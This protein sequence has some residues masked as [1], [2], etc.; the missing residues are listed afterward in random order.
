MALT[1]RR[2]THA[3]ASAGFSATLAGLTMLMLVAP[4][5][6]ARADECTAIAERIASLREA[7]DLTA[8]DAAFAA[9]SR[10]DSPCSDK[11]RYCIGRSAALGYVA[12]L[13][14]LSRKEQNRGGAAPP[15]EMEAL[16]ARGRNLGAPW[17]LLVALGDLQL[18]QAKAAHDG[19][20]YGEAAL[21]YQLALLELTDEPAC[22]EYGEPPAASARQIGEIYEHM[23]TALLLAAPIKLATSKCS[24]CQWAFLS[25]I[26]DFTPAVR[27]LPITFAANS[28]EPTAEGR[29]AIAAL[30]Q[31]INARKLPRIVLS[32]H[33]DQT[34]SAD[35]NLKLSDRRLATVER[36]LKEGGFA[37]TVVKEPKGKSEP[38]Q[39]GDLASYAPEEIQRLN[40][41]I[42]LRAF[43]AGEA[44]S[45][46]R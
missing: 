17:Q 2:S 24:V 27:P 32:G 18:D 8:L 35:F 22:L 25:P 41:R 12:E 46:S 4:S 1:P 15:D 9:A 34:G 20:R 23:S 7:H 45:C 36:M 16:L 38:Y 44:P 28:V 6:P 21:D 43:A 19:A 39:S 26:R 13:Y 37:G 3:L 40:R 10:A 11:A 29:A 30:L 14:A 42:E 33:A 31:C 5:S